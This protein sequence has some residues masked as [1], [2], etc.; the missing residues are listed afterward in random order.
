[1]SLDL[2][3]AKILYVTIEHMK[4]ELQNKVGLTDLHPLKK[5]VL[6]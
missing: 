4:S 3:S 2:V 5:E 1:M 6:D